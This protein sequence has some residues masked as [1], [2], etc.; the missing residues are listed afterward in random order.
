MSDLIPALFPWLSFQLAALG[1]LLS[2]ARSMEP[3]TGG[4]RHRKGDAVPNRARVHRSAARRA[5]VPLD[6]SA[7]R[8]VRPYLPREFFLIREA[9][10]A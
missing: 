3:A 8:L 9:G 2:L 6:G 10:A 7:S 4:G 5:E 1:L